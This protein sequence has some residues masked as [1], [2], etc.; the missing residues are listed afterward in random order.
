[1]TP[2]QSAIYRRAL[3]VHGGAGAAYLGLTMLV[4]WPL[5]LNFATAV[6]GGGDS[7]QFYWN[8][9]WIERALVE[10]Q[11]SPFFTTLVHFPHGSDLYFH[12]LNLLPSVLVMPVVALFGLAVGYNVIAFAGFVLGG[13]GAYRLAH[14]LLPDGNAT[15]RHLAAFV[16]GAAFTFTSYH[17]VH[18]LGHLDMMSVQWLPLYALFLF[19]T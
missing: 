1:M 7:W 17:V 6:P 9:W 2:V 19:K 3:V 5:V 16:A 11:T 12:T 15:E 14:Y 8:L 10:L 18:L 13:Y 4:T